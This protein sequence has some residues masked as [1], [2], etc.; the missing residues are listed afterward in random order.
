MMPRRADPREI[1]AHAEL[2]NWPSYRE[3]HAET[4]ISLSNITAARRA[5]VTCGLIAR[6]EDRDKLSATIPSAFSGIVHVLKSGGR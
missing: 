4:G 5:L 2:V 6:L 1:V 3:I